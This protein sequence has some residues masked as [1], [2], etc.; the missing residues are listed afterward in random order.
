MKRV[1][2]NINGKKFPCMPLMGAFLRYKKETGADYEPTES[3]TANCTFL[4][5]CVQSACNREKVAFD[6]SLDD[7]ADSVSLDELKNVSEKMFQS[8]TEGEGETV[9]RGGKK[10]Q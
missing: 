9:Q 7:F 2:I 8:E 3:V 5:C 4:Y 10:K 6:M 1:T